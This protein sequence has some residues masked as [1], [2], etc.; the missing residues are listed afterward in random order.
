MLSNIP[1]AVRFP[2]ASFIFV[3]FVFFT[4]FAAS[5]APTPLYQVY[6][7]AWGFDSISL[8]VVFSVYALGMLA[9]LLFIGS[10]S[11]FL[12]RKPVLFVAIVLEVFSMLLF[13]QSNSV[14]GL[15]LARFC[16]GVAT[17]V[18]TAVLGAFLLD[19]DEEKG[20]IYSSVVPLAGVGSG[21]IFSSLTVDFGLSPLHLV[22]L[23][24]LVILLSQLVTLT[25]LDEPISRR[26]GAIRS[27][28]PVL[29]IPAP[30]REMFFIILP[31]NT[32]VWS[33]NGFFLSLVPS[34]VRFTS[35]S[36]TAIS[37]G[38]VVGLMSFAGSISVMFLKKR[39]FSF[40]L[41]LGVALLALG[42]F[43]IL[44]AVYSG[45]APLF[46]VFTVVAGVGAGSSF[47][48]FTKCLL[49]LSPVGERAGLISAYYVV[50]QLAL[51]IPSVTTG[52]LIKFVGITSAT[53]F[54]GAFVLI[55]LG[56][57]SCLM[58]WRA[59]ALRIDEGVSP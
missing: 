24:I 53:Y 10:L 25:C 21:V 46:Y 31:M 34:L 45:M 40:T 4:F 44:G 35:P 48:S 36:S 52:V 15:I 43:G 16:Q 37:A 59:N 18:A 30:A 54:Y 56:V 19:I 5:S 41:P 50:S 58:V 14:Q 27:L 1:N 29:H 22:Y 17:G 2:R 38:I 51:I 8:T 13:L 9:S 39:D 3:S 23:T 33:L 28:K 47:V 6:Q 55:L 42:V 12:G 20:S 26:R 11:D 57:S 49:P 7:K 32:A